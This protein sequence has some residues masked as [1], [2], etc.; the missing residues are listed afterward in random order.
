MPEKTYAQQVKESLKLETYR[1]LLIN[2]AGHSK[3]IG[4]CPWDAGFGC[5]ADKGVPEDSCP[6]EN[7]DYQHGQ[8]C[9]HKV[10]EN[11]G[12]DTSILDK[13]QSGGSVDSQAEVP[14]VQ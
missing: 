3:T 13:E 10:L 9:W 1:Q 5:L 6:C 12:L 8:E 2:F 7:W 11:E 4:G 14:E